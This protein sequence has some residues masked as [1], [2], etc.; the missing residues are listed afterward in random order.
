MLSRRQ[1]STALSQLSR[2]TPTP[3]DLLTIFAQGDNESDR[4]IIL[5]RGALVEEALQRAILNRMRSLNHAERRRLFDNP[6]APL[7]SFSGK[8][9]IAYA[10]KLIGPST[11]DDLDCIREI[12]NAFAHTIVN[13]DFST[14][15]VMDHCAHLQLPARFPPGSGPHD[16]SWPPSTAEPRRLFLATAQLLWVYLLDAANDRHSLP[17]E[18]YF[19]I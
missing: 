15:E 10:I 12:R 11:R 4:S 6:F 14:K 1:T 8:I 9:A 7:S 2:R 17:D 5:I 16:L 19:L 3:V 13:I 18:A